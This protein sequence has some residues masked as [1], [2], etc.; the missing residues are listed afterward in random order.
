MQSV[1]ARHIVC[2]PVG[3]RHSERREL[4]V[5]QGAARAPTGYPVLSSEAGLWGGP[6]WEMPVRVGFSSGTMQG[7]ALPRAQA[8]SCLGSQRLLSSP[9]LD[10]K[11][12]ISLTTQS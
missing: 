5:S 1:S 2:P 6:G 3:A 7:V 12:L 10:A 4:W 11:L 9:F 8:T